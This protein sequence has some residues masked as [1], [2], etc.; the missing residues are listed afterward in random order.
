MSN[1]AEDSAIVGIQA[2]TVHID[3]YY[4]LPPNPTLE[5][6]F[7]L[8]LNYLRGGSAENARA[9]ICAAVLDGYVTSRSCFYLLLVLLSGRTLQQV[10]E[11]ELEILHRARKDLTGH[12]EDQWTQGIKA[13]GTVVTSL[14]KKG[15]DAQAEADLGALPP[16][17]RDEILRNLEI[18]LSGPTLEAFWT[19]S[20]EAAEKDRFGGNRKERTW[21]FFHPMP[22]GPRARPVR[23]MMITAGDRL[24][25]TAAS[26]FTAL[27]LGYLVIVSWQHTWSSTLFAVA[28]LTGGA[29]VCAR[30]APV[31][32]FRVIR[33]RLKDE[34]WSS[35]AQDEADDRRR[36]F[37]GEIDRQFKH[38][39]GRYVPENTDRDAW[40]AAT[41]GIRQHLRDEVVEVYRE[42]RIEAKKVAWLTRHL[43]HDVKTNWEK[44]THRAYRTELH[45]PARMK[46]TCVLAVTVMSVGVALV[47][48]NALHLRPV[49]VIA[50]T[51]LLALVARFAVPAWLRITCERLR[52]AADEAEHAEKKARR[53]D[54]LER[55]RAKLIDRP[56]DVDMAAW[57][58]C[59]RKILMAD[60]MRHYK[61]AAS[62]IVALAFIEGHAEDYDRAS[63]R[64]GPWRYSRYEVLVFLLTNDGV[65]QMKA[66]LDFPKA[67]FH[68]R[69]RIN[70][71][72]DAVASVSATAADDGDKEFELTLMTGRTIK[73]AVTG[74]SPQTGDGAP[75]MSQITLDTA[76][77]GNTL[78]VLEGI[79]A[80]GKQWIQNE[81]RRGKIKLDDLT[82]I[83]E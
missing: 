51:A 67:T 65:R 40:L 45:V 17:Q 28:L 25:L 81:R 33:L 68:N 58:D 20:F 22:A 6:R 80:E 2:G 23:P 26:G 71:R 66:E 42:E 11:E 82:N 79:A 12:P 60:A 15:F 77:L 76:G 49:S 55:W 3:K 32:N 29:H 35:P 46:V 31:W 52:H 13:I 59:D 14:Q 62:D 19:R 61:L 37:A 4:E 75:S 72:Y 57:L 43:V 27:G 18:F 30:L 63:F 78:H 8:G 41:K 16:E 10:P 24:G 50:L 64:K 69:S 34:E 70:F 39:F 56:N 36:G 83:F 73:V 53:T 44:G 54:A 21:K 1:Y 74:Q 48:W 7:E 38:Y 5:D 9:V 47:G